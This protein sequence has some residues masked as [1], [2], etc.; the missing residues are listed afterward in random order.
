MNVNFIS[1]NDILY[2]T[3]Y[4][5]VAFLLLVGILI[6]FFYYSV[7]KINKI[8]ILQKNQEIQHQKE[9]VNSILKTQEAERKRI[10]Q[11]LHD[12]ISSKLNI[13]SLNANLLQTENVSENEK[14]NITNTILTYTKLVI[15][16]SRRIAHDLLPPVFQNFGL[17]AAISE[18]CDELN[19]KGEFNIEYY[20]DCSFENLNE[21]KQLHIFR[22]V[23]ELVNNSIV[24]GKAKNIYL[25]FFKTN[26]KIILDFVDNG[27]GFNPNIQKTRLGIGTRNIESR[28]NFL[29]G[30]L[31]VTSEQNLGVKYIIEFNTYEKN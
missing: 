3:I 28:V 27:I 9:L 13:I 5:G 20:N 1:E 7:K 10:A 6:L 2:I 12:D 31:K 22:I 24:H 4:T 19:R 14:A 17:H 15:E 18:L 8:E 30:T 26:E 23:Q 21:T 16:D 25:F 29:E 11:D